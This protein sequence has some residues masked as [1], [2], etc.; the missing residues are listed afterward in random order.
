MQVVVFGSLNYD[1]TLWL[2]RMP[3]PDET[4]VADRLEEFGG[5]PF[6]SGLE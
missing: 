1:V 4:L 2:P 3:A 6:T 5:K